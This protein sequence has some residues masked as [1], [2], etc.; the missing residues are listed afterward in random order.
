VAGAVVAGAVVAGAVVAGAVVAGADSLRFVII[1]CSVIAVV[2]MF[3]LLLCIMELG[4][5][6]IFIIKYNYKIYK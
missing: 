6:S 1:A 3:V 5:T 2:R 4:M